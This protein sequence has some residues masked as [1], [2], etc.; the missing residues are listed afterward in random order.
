MALK[1]MGCGC[2]SCTKCGRIV[3]FSDECSDMRDFE[4]TCS[5]PE[6]L[7]PSLKAIRD[8]VKSSNAI[9]DG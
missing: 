5:C 4:R 3:K 1:K 8:L 2:D 7:Q 6:E 9:G